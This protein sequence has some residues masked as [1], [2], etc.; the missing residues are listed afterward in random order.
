MRKQLLDDM[1]ELSVILKKALDDALRDT[2]TKSGM[3]IF[4]MHKRELEVCEIAENRMIEAGLV[5]K[6]YSG[7]L[8]KELSVFFFMEYDE[9]KNSFIFD[10]DCDEFIDEAIEQAD[11]AMKNPC[12]M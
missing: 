10:Y 12:E 7:H 11:K 3:N 9:L 4:D 6:S 1:E 5:D 8:Q 2:R